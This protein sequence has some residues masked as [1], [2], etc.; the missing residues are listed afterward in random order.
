MPY[1]LLTLLALLVATAPNA[2]AEDALSP[3]ELE[4]G[5]I[6]LKDEI[7]AANDEIEVAE[8]QR[9]ILIRRKAPEQAREVSNRITALKAKVRRL[10]T[11]SVEDYARVVRAE[12]AELKAKQEEAARE[13]AARKCL[14]PMREL[15]Q[16]GPLAIHDCQMIK[17]STAAG[18]KTWGAL[19]MTQTGILPDGHPVLIVQVIATGDKPVESYEISFEVIDSFGEAVVNRRDNDRVFVERR[20]LSAPLTRGQTDTAMNWGDKHYQNAFTAKA[21]VS[22][23]RL[24]DGTVWEQSREDAAKKPHAL[25]ESERVDVWIPRECRD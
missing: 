23:V 6:R 3:D 9:R 2:R 20:T 4:A 17:N 11:T 16:C 1:A 14:P 12:K 19:R 18:V 8:Q 10:R 15:A 21:W 5:R 22:R 13:E 25:R 7:A 24:A